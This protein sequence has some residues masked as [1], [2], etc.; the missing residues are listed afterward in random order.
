MIFNKKYKHIIWDW[1]G[2]ILDDA[3]LCVKTL[4]EILSRRNMQTITLQEY[5]KSF[6]FPVI[7]YYR[8]V[9]FNFETESF[10][11]IAAEYI[12]AYESQL[13][14]CNIQKGAVETMEKIK[15]PV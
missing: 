9:G 4:N 3:W 2:T 1:N 10:D 11:I 14:K 15:R 12:S 6:G 5:Q 7:D 13:S 8:K